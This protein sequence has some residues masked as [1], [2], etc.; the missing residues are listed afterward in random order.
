MPRPANA[1]APSHLF[2]LLLIV[3]AAL[4]TRSRVTAI[5]THQI[6]LRIC[7]RIPLHPEGAGGWHFGQRG[8]EQVQA[9]AGFAAGFVLCVKPPV[10]FVQP[11]TV[12]YVVEAMGAVGG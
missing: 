2:Y 11:A 1:A 5:A 3:A 12:V 6:P 10:A 7:D 8:A 4:Q 9:V